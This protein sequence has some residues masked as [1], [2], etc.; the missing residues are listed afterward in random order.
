MAKEEKQRA[1]EEEAARLK[2]ASTQSKA[3]LQ[4]LRES[5]A[6]EQADKE[7]KRL[8]IQRSLLE[9][10]KAREAAAAA[11]V[12][13]A[14]AA[15]EVARERGRNLWDEYE[16]RVAAAHADP[17]LMAGFPERSYGRS[18]EERYWPE[19]ISYFDDPKNKSV[20][21]GIPA[22][23]EAAKEQ[24]LP[25]GAAQAH[26]TTVAAA[27]RARLASM[28]LAERDTAAFHEEELPPHLQRADE[29]QLLLTALL[30][31]SYG[32]EISQEEVNNRVHLLLHHPEY[33]REDY[34]SLLPT[35]ET[36]FDIPS[37]QAQKGLADT[38][39]KNLLAPRQ[40]AAHSPP[41]YKSSLE[42]M[43][44]YKGRGLSKLKKRIHK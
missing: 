15:K 36:R 30:T 13:A 33:K 35:L 21:Y 11:A 8:E 3:G 37:L 7:A 38:A 14:A 39:A 17:S 26:L 9:Q 32:K 1:F 2:K 34:I 25:T 23:R 19:D 44:H 6:V 20:S 24:M 41:Q 28:G 22:R 5:A 4:R 12:A 31:P 16:E 18:R 29:R 27:A 10:Y 40:T 43:G 42:F